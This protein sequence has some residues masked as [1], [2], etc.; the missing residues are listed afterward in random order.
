[1]EKWIAP[2]AIALLAVIAVLTIGGGV[3]A[4]FI[5]EG[6]LN[7]VERLERVVQC[8]HSPECRVFVERAI[9]EILRHA[10]RSPSGK[11][12]VSRDGG[13]ALRVV[14][15]DGGIVIVPA[16]EAAP[17]PPKAT[18]APSPSK[19]PQGKDTPKSIEEP[20]SSPAPAQPPSQGIQQPEPKQ[21]SPPP[22]YQPPPI[23]AAPDDLL[24]EK[25]KEAAGNVVEFTCTTIK[26]LN[27]ICEVE[28]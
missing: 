23:S 25:V 14:P 4:Y 9:R 16:P 28:G 15:R 21:E 17:T 1:M 22:E 3:L 10:K 8:Q 2:R 6:D 24:P 11:L 20:S 13:V 26:E 27:G 5:R 19:P 7:R 18:S 12:E